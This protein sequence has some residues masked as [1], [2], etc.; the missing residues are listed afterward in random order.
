MNL[1]ENELSIFRNVSCDV[2][3]DLVWKKT[4]SLLTSSHDLAYHQ[5]VVEVDFRGDIA[6]DGLLVGR[7]LWVEAANSSAPADGAAVCPIWLAGTN[8]FDVGAIGAL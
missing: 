5:V 2:L 7:P 6:R 3:L 1:V 8:G 4:F